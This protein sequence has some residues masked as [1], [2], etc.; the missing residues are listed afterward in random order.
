MLRSLY[1]VM[2]IVAHV[3]G[4]IILSTLKW[5]IQSTEFEMSLHW[6]LG[7]LLSVVLPFRGTYSYVV[8]VH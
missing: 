8:N 3:S 2:M 1:S 5:S 6:H 7:L 4:F